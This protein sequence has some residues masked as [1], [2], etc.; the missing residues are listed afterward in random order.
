M[1]T[2]HDNIV[3]EKDKSRTALLLID[4]INAM[5]FPGGEE[6]YKKALP[7]SE[8]IRK[9]KKEAKG[10]GIPVIYVNDNFG[11][12]QSDLP[13]ILY[14]FI[15]ENVK[16]RQIIEHLIPDKDDYIVIKP[17]HSGFYQTVLSTLLDHLEIHTLIITGFAGDQ[18]VMYTA[19][20]GYMRDYRIHIP[21]DCT[22]SESEKWNDM[23]LKLMKKN[24]KADL[25]PSSELRLADW[26]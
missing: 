1:P 17:K 26:K 2:S 10:H 19:Q 18:C 25:T 13:K 6:L 7:V 9:L 16:G 11:K 15:E 23:A 4:V 21:S 5:E 8:R 22:A 14:S 3:N 20:D 24:L 12:W